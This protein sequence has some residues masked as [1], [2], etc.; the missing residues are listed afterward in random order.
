MAVALRL[1]ELLRVARVN[2]IEAQIPTLLRGMAPSTQERNI[3][4]VHLKRLN[5][6]ARWS[7]PAL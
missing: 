5:A 1:M 3:S 7:H 2:G 4:N 6:D